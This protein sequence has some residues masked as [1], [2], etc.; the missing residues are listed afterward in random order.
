ML[1]MFCVWSMPVLLG[2]TFHLVNLVLCIQ[3]FKSYMLMCLFYCLGYLV[4]MPSFSQGK[5]LIYVFVQFLSHF[6][7]FPCM[8]YNL[9]FSMINVCNAV[10]FR[11]N[12]GDVS[13]IEL[14]FPAVTNPNSNSD[15]SII[16]FLRT[17]TLVGDS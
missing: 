3:Y 14:I 5:I 4:L 16:T 12:T 6:T 1:L 10:G 15:K 11:L 2:L 7:Q 17:L 9:I 8:H 13:L